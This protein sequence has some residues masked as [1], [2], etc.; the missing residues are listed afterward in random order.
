MPAI[1]EPGTG[2]HFYELSHR[3]GYNAPTYPGF[4]DIKLER[5]TYHAKHGVMTQ[6]IVANFHTSTHANAPVH[7]V[8]MAKG[9]GEVAVDRF[10]GNG[11][12]LDIPKGKWELVTAD[13][14]KAAR[15]RIEAD[16]IVVI[17]TGWHHRYADSQ[18]Y[19]GYAPGLAPDAAEFLVKRKAKLVA[20]DTPHVD[21]PLAT[22]MGPHRNG[23]QIKKIAPEYKAEKKRDPMKDFPVWNAAHKILLAA[24][25]PTIE[26]VGGD[27]DEVTGKRCTFHAYPWRWREG[28]AS[29]IRLVAILDPGGEYRVESGRRR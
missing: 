26:Q 8:P 9:I 11:V 22:S 17:N 14:L 7:L 24:D 13:D 3:W 19:F 20:V 12:V 28:D 6:K 21:H 4:E 23:P 25:I 27:V 15:P 5:I 16:D 29:V 2:L 10:F 18:E 1:V